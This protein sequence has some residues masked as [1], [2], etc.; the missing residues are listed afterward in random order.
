MYVNGDLCVSFSRY[1]AYVAEE[2]VG[3]MKIESIFRPKRTKNLEHK[4]TPIKDT[5]PKR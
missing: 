5:F 1:C 2:P 3:L 4:W